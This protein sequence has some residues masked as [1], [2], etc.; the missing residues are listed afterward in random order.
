ME[1][2][3][4]NLGITLL[5]KKVVEYFNNPNLKI[6]SLKNKP[7]SKIALISPKDK[8]ISNESKEFIDFITNCNLSHK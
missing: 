7:K 8:D 1:L 6:V 5:T 2:V 3:S 4:E